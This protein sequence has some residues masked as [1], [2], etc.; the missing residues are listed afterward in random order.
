MQAG[1]KALAL[2]SHES[3]EVRAALVPLYGIFPTLSKAVLKIL[4]EALKVD[5]VSLASER[6]YCACQPGRNKKLFAVCGVHALV[7]CSRCG[8]HCMIDR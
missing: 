5:H 2:S 8:F 1:V 3:L 4:H 7:E 6:T